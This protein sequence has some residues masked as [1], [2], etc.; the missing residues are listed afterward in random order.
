MLDLT[1]LQSVTKLFVFLIPW[2]QIKYHALDFRSNPTLAASA[3]I[4][5]RVVE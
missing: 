1:T 4:E 2:E 3:G 5:E